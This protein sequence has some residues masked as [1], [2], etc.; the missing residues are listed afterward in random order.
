MIEKDLRACMPAMRMFKRMD[1]N[2]EAF[3][4]FVDDM[5][6]RF[7]EGT[8]PKRDVFGA[9]LVNRWR[10]IL[11]SAHVAFVAVAIGCVR[12]ARGAFQYWS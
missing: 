5:E 4:A 1:Q 3:E 9:R 6:R 11:L 2:I 8:L 10:L 7:K 12:A